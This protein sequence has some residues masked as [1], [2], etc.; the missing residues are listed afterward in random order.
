MHLDGRAIIVV[1]SKCISR[2]QLSNR[3]RVA[4]WFVR[5]NGASCEMDVILTCDIGASEARSAM[6][7]FAIIGEPT[8]QCWH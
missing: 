8:K 5:P 4:F 1:D 2:R 7:A 6:T 3:P